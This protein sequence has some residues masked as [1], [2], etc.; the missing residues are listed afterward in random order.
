MAFVV[1][2]FK[3]FDDKYCQYSRLSFSCHMAFM[4]AFHVYLQ[5]GLKGLT[6]FYRYRCMKQSM[7]QQCLRLL[8]PSTSVDPHQVR[9]DDEF[10]VFI[11]TLHIA[12]NQDLHKVLCYSMWC[13][14]W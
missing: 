12:V 8:F 3:M 7:L 4:V 14:L 5:E 6:R 13:C 9:L 2:I 11:K 1:A 10:V